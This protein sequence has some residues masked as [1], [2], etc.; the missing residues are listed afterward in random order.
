VSDE[1]RARRVHVS[2]R[3]Q[4]VGYRYFVFCA[5]QQIGVTGYVRNLAD[6]TVEVYAVGT[7]AQLRTF[8]EELQRGP[9]DAIV[10][11]VDEADAEVIPEFASRFSIQ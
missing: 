8:L 1:K 4:G 5:A 2:G 6:G 11:D 7:A 9:Q 3:V 10:K